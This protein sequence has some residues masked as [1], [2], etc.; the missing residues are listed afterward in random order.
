MTRARRTRWSSS[1]SPAISPSS[2]SSRRSTRWCG[3]AI[4]TCRS[5]AWPG[6]GRASTSCAPGRK[7]SIEATRRARPGGVREA[8]GAAALR[9][10]R[11]RGRGDLRRSCAGRW[12]ARRGPPTTWRFRRAC[13]RPWSSGLAGAGMRRRRA[14]GR[15]EAVR[16]RP[17]LGRGAQRHAAR[18]TSPRRRSSAS[19]T[20]WARSRCRTCSTSA[21]P[22]RSSSRSGTAT[23]STGSRS[24]WPRRF[25][26]EGRGKFYEEA[27][28]IRDVVQNHLL[29]VVSLLAMEAPGGRG[30]ESVRDEK[31]Q[32]FRSM[33][34][35]AAGR[36]RARPVPRL[37][38]RAGRG[39]RL[40]WSRRSPRCGSTS[41]RGAGPAC[42]STSAPAS[43]CR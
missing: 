24:R 23:T 17:R 3:A 26:V 37:P 10:R 31:A 42:R 41:T 43:T 19:T 15:R 13:S 35:L 27:G 20:T 14:R 21:S 1:A 33:R 36:R 28:A 25:G 16:P 5:S 7:R 8:V 29:Q 9:R 22:T 40:A 11:L 2:R 30:T 34:P 32:A 6:P 4:S 12:A 39:R 38:R 18:S